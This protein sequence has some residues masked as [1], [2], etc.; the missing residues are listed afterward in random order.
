MKDNRDQDGLSFVWDAKGL[1]VGLRGGLIV[2][3]GTFGIRK[4]GERMNE[5]K[6]SYVKM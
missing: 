6:K 5:G 3:H 1:V 4:D 2:D